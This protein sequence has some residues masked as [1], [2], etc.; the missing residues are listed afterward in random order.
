MSS[1]SQE[2]DSENTLEG[3]QSAKLE[4][5]YAIGG[6][7]VSSLSVTHSAIRQEIEVELN[8]PNLKWDMESNRSWCSVVEEEHRGSGTVTVEIAANEDFEAREPATLTF[9]AGEFRGFSIM[10]SQTASAF[11]IS[12][13][14]FVEDASGRTLTA[15]VTTLEGTEWTAE[16]NGWLEVTRNPAVANDGFSTVELSVSLN[17]NVGEGRYGAVTL[18]GGGES[19]SIWVYQFGQD[20]EYDDAGNIFFSLGDKDSLSFTAP[21]YAVK[22]VQTPSFATSSIAVNGDGTATV[23]IALDS[24]LS[25]C[26]ETR[27]VPV[28]VTL[29]NALSSVV[30]LPPMIQNYLPAHGLVT[31]KGMV[32]FAKAIAEGAPVSDWEDGGV[33]N[34]LQDIDMSEIS[35]WEGIGTSDKPFAGTFNGNSHTI[36]NLK[37]SAHGIFGYCSGASVCN[38][39]IGKGT[40]LYFSG[41]FSSGQGCLGG[42]V[43]VAEGTSVSGCSFAGDMEFAG[44]ND[45]EDPCYVGGIVG[46]ADAASSVKDCKTSG[47]ITISTPNA[48]NG[49]CY[50]GGIAGLSL[51]ALT[52]GEMTGQLN[53]TS[54][55]GTIFAGGIQGALAGGASVSNNSFMGSIVLGGNSAYVHLGGLYGSVRS[56]RDFDFASDKSVAMGSISVESFAVSTSTQ[57]YAGGF[58]GKAEGGVSLSFKDYEIQTSISLDQ[59]ANRQAAYICIG[60]VL[61]GCDPEEKAGSM[62]FKGITNQ[63]IRSTAYAGNTVGSR[64]SHGFLG[65]IAGF[66]NG[67]AVFTSCTNNGAVGDITS[68][69]YTCANSKQYLFLAG[70]IAGVALGGDAEFRDCANNGT[71]TVN[72]YSNVVP[73]GTSGGWY[74]SCGA[75]G[76]LGAFDYKP[77][78]VSGKLTMTGCVNNGNIVSYRGC[79]AGIV[80]Y[81]RNATI[82]SCSNY[83]DMNATSAN[84][85]NKGGIACVLSQSEVSG[86]TAKCNIFCSNP[87]SAVQSPG[88]IVSISLGG[89]VSISGCAWY[90]ALTV[91]RSDQSCYVGGIIST[92]EEDTVVKDCKFGGKIL[93]VDM[94]E[95]NVAEYASGNSLGSISGITLWN[96]NL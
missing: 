12:Q 93:G 43:S 81:A 23:T 32:A 63:G 82:S 94:S 38:V 13:P 90:G 89:G 66:I 61:G 44:Y 62:T 50:T 8:N 26:S 58:A 24:N 1:C 6:S 92:A 36:S 95:N 71:V 52:N 64:I 69:S 34:V 73:G 39:S 91:N 78:S 21:A 47:K 29:A 37:N 30:S 48:S 27:E 75:A 10:V 9:V 16:G 67:D 76:I 79:S 4:V 54:G 74:T 33:V 28:S 68:S 22:S 65:G 80:A 5:S 35:G 11:L 84:A 25:D 55:A 17:P 77:V 40:S 14:Y 2:E 86:C 42:I 7:S 31:A 85:A 59:T 60:G 53:L 49:V 96:G 51:G 57:V 46:L 87:A 20:I 18:T 41:D 70:G 83:G 72:H 3:R 19:D 15:K 88:G 56:D 45:D